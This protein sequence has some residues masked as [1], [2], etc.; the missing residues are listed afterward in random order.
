[1]QEAG[2]ELHVPHVFEI[3]VLSALRRHARRSLS[4]E[5]GAK[6]IEDLM[7]MKLTRYPHTALLWR[8]WEL[9]DNLTAYDAAYVALAETLGTPLITLDAKLSQ[10]RVSGPL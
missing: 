6:L 10:A 5:R 1:M 2:G 4:Q 9:R 8:I 3:E 7:T